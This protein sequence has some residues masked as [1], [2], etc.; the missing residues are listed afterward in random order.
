MLALRCGAVV[1]ISGQ[2]APAVREA[3]SRKVMQEVYRYLIPALWLAWLL[4]WSVAAI[5]SKAT[6]REESFASRLSHIIPL[7][8]GV[9]LLAT[10]RVP[11]AWLTARFVPPAAGWWWLGAILVASGLAISVAARLSLGANWS[12]MVTLKQEHELIRTGPYRWARHPI[13]TGLLL[14]VLGTAIALG[15]WRGVIALVL[16]TAAFLRKIAI[17]ERFLREHF[18]EVHAHYSRKVPSLVPLHRR[19][20]G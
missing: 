18:G 4:Y 2:D 7:A 16:V 20:P 5:G 1:Q 12:S 6:A 14:A 13:Y 10:L 17:E 8:V 15:E 11:M 3:A 9:A 19:D